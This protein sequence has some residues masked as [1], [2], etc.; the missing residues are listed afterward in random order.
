M[1]FS[2]I[3]PRRCKAESLKGWSLP[4]SQQVISGYAPGEVAQCRDGPYYGFATSLMTVWLCNAAAQMKR[5]LNGQDFPDRERQSRQRQCR[6]PH[7][8]GAVSARE[9][10]ADRHPCRLR[11]L[12]MWRLRRASR[13]QGGKILYHARGYG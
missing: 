3:S 7:I 10:A 8:A 11:Y 6:P 5:V 2:P 1:S 12:A 13:R 9:S 4:K